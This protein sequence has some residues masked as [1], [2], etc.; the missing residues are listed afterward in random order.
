M[1]VC[2][3]SET[4]PLINILRLLSI[5][6]FKLPSSNLILTSFLVNFFINAATAVAQAAVPH[7]FVNPA[8]RSQTFTVIL[9]SLS[10]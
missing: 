2:F 7:A 3:I 9:F 4:G 10:I 8:P 6:I 5:L 1:L